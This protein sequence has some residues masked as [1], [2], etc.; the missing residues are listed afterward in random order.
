MTSHDSSTRTSDD[1]DSAGTGA[2]H[3]PVRSGS[4]RSRSMMAVAYTLATVLGGIGALVVLVSTLTSS[5]DASMLDVALWGA[6]AVLL[7]GS[8]ANEWWL[9]DRAEERSQRI[10]EGVEPEEI[11]GIA[12]VSSGEIDTIRRLRVA[13]PGL[14]L[15]DARD[16][17]KGHQHES[18]ST[19]H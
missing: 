19:R 17:V 18:S 12:E 11:A 5:A 9:R 2:S 8:A 16:L 4:T 14:G 15:M 10:V 6:L 7:F 3:G 13:H 1:P